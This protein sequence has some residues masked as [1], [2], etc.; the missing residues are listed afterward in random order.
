M[1][2]TFQLLREETLKPGAN[3]QDILR[4][5][6]ALAVRL[7]MKP[8]AAW[9]ELELN[10]YPLSARLPDYRVVA[11][12]SC[13]KLSNQ[14]IEVERVLVP[15]PF[16]PADLQHETGHSHLR[17]GIADYLPLMV[18]RRSDE[19]FDY[20]PEHHVKRLNQLPNLPV[21]LV[22]RQAWKVLPRQAIR[23]LVE[24]IRVQLLRM[25]LEMETRA[26]RMAMADADL[27]RAAN[28]HY[29]LPP[30]SRLG[31]VGMQIAK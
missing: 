24:G 4:R 23:D 31:R 10:G 16:V 19:L 14:R 11:V 3:L 6:H 9:I 28:G 22:C 18:G 26:P 27:P 7:Q 15:T 20:W 13:M 17:N 30:Q 21:D 5:C 29:P 8:A 2:K 12:H 1:R 25:L